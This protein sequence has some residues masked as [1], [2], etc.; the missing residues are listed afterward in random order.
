[1]DNQFLRKIKAYGDISRQMEELENEETEEA[2]NQIAKLQ[3]RLDIEI[4]LQVARRKSD[5]T[6]QEQIIF[7]QKTKNKVM[8][9]LKNDLSC[10][11]NPECDFE[12][13]GDKIEILNDNENGFY[14]ID[15][16]GKS[17]PL[18]LG[19][20]LTD[21][22]WNI[23]YVAK[24]G[25]V[26]RSVH[27]QIMLERAKSRLKTL[28]D[29]QISKDKMSSKYIPA[30]RKYSYQHYA[31][32]L[33]KGPV[34]SNI[35]E[36]FGLISERM[37]FNFLRKIS[38]DCGIDFKIE[39]TDIYEDISHK[40]DFIIS[41]KINGRTQEDKIQLTTMRRSEDLEKK[42]RD[43]QELRT[44][45]PMKFNV[46]LVQFNGRNFNESYKAWIDTG[47]RPG[48]PDKLLEDEVKTDILYKS[49]A[50]LYSREEIASIVAKA[51]LNK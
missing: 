46:R 29:L 6:S 30:R 23:E 22:S 7:M 18:T 50:S 25:T 27:K 9:E 48:G 51:K 17:H 47:A 36:E 19:E 12:K 10:L 21:N 8:D 40:T 38:I 39:E 33:L 42:E 28:F 1:M 37:V 41:R 4:E 44:K 14:Y 35:G 3:N 49:L 16:S 45:H 32:Q 24:K 5:R 15:S 13:Q 26:P 11:D 43:L 34:R 31:L 2:V 20:I